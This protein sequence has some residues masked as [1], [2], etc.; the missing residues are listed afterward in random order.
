VAGG[1][2][3]GLRDSFSITIDVEM[4]ETG[5]VGLVG[6]FCPCLGHDVQD[7]CQVRLIHVNGLPLVVLG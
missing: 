5:S 7:S 6:A 3:L 2:T 4:E 1:G